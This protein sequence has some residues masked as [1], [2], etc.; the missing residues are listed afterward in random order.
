MQHYWTSFLHSTIHLKPFV[1]KCNNEQM[2]ALRDINVHTCI[3][4]MVWL[5]NMCVGVYTI[6]T[7]ATYTL[8][9]FVINCS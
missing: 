4:A 7:I 8:W 3:S 5:Y 2:N 1:Y 9:T 6:I